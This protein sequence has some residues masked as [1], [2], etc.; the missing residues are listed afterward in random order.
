MYYWLEITQDK[1]ELPLA[2][3]DTARE[4]ANLRG[5]KKEAVTTAVWRYEHLGIGTR[6]RRVRV[7]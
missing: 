7:C 4:L 1:Y 2:V 3:A 5:L 6:F